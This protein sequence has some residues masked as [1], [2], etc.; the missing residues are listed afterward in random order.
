MVDN[1]ADV[2]I[3]ARFACVLRYVRMKLVDVALSKRREDDPHKSRCFSCGAAGLE[4][5]QDCVGRD[6]PGGVRQVF[7]VSR[8][9]FLT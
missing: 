8:H 6:A 1:A 9:H 7:L 2:T 4:A 5:G 3:G